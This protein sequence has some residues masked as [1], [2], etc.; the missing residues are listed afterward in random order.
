MKHTLSMINSWINLESVKKRYNGAIFVGEFPIEKDAD[1]CGA[2]FWQPKP[3][4]HHSNYFMLYY[5]GFRESVF[6]TSGEKQASR[7]YHGVITPKGDFIYS[8]HR[9]DYVVHD[10]C[11][12]DGG[13]SYTKRND[14]GKD[15]KFIIEG[16]E[17]KIL[18]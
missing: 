8:R 11:V 7:V 9:H 1:V 13:D 10:G 6:I 3:Q 17:I 12:I 2:L 14:L 16:P 4:G 15:V 18:E 5:C